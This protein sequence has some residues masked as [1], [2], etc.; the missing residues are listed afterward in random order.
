[1]SFKSIDPYSNNL[2]WYIKKPKR[3]LGEIFQTVL[4]DNKMEGFVC[5]LQPHHSGYLRLKQAL[6]K[7]QKIKKSGGWHKVPAREKLRKGDYGIRIGAL[8]SIG[9]ASSICSF[10]AKNSYKRRFSRDRLR[11]LFSETRFME[12]MV[13]LIVVKF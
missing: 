10:G 4:Y 8:R 12:S 13:C 11:I 2:N 6:L 9:C 3:K 5:A 1:M 7:Y